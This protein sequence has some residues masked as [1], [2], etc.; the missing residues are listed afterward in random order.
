M[1][2]AVRS[3]VCVNMRPQAL[4]STVDSHCICKFICKPEMRRAPLRS[5]EDRRRGRRT[6]RL[7]LVLPAEPEQ[8]SSCVLPSA[9][10]SAR[11][12]HCSWLRSPRLWAF[13]V[14]NGPHAHVESGV[15]TRK[16][17]GLCL[18]RKC[19]CREAA[20]L[21][22]VSSAFTRQYGLSTRCTRQTSCTRTGW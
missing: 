10:A 4:G 9:H 15:P 12:C 22:A 5:L 19:H 1:T 13:A 3:S 20:A 17:A 21:E 16:K 8:H 11:A 6:V 18:C 2:K 14:G 7:T